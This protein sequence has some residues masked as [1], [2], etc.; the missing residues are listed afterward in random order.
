VLLSNNDAWVG[1][2]NGV[3]V[4]ISNEYK[5]AEDCLGL[6]KKRKNNNAR[7]QHQ[8]LKRNQEKILF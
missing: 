2:G 3:D 6:S 7:S 8:I 4:L 5:G 1:L